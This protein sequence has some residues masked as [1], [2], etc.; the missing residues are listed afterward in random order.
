MIFAIW[1]EL[2]ESRNLKIQMKSTVKLGIS[3]NLPKMW[4]YKFWVLVTS[5]HPTPVRYSVILKKLKCFTRRSIAHTQAASV[6]PTFYH[7][8]NQH[9][10]AVLQKIGGKKLPLS[11]NNNLFNRRQFIM[12][13]Y[14]LFILNCPHK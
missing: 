8:F 6:K 4:T 14:N 7:V 12:Y 5:P 11:S 2:M 3:W 13:C 10:E 1:K 9:V